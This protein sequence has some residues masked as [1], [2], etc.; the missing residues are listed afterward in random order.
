[1]NDEQIYI[2]VATGHDREK[3]RAM[4]A[5]SSQETIY[6]RFHSPYPEI[7]EWMVDLMLDTDHHDR[8]VLVA[9]AEENVVGHAMYARLGSGTGAELAIVVEDGWQSK[10]IGK[11]LLSE[12]AARARRSGIEIFTAEV[13]A[14]NGRMLGLADTFFG[15]RYTMEDGTYHVRM[16]L[17]A[18]VM[19]EVAPQPVPQAA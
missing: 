2:R 14:T 19:A 12:L 9:V 17:R 11:S 15:T 18:Y 3:L 16:P 8:E 7:P 13:L 4:F 10:G 5:R 6:R 1:M